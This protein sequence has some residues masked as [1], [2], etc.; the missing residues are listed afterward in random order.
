MQQSPEHDTLRAEANQNS[1]KM[2]LTLKINRLILL[3]NVI[4]NQLPRFVFP[5][6]ET[7]KNS[8]KSALLWQTLF[9]RKHQNFSIA[10]QPVTEV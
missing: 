2:A 6:K 8:L 9:F 4:T 7:E 5:I 1:A 3:H 10:S